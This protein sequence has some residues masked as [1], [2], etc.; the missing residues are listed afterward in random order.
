MNPFKPK[1]RSFNKHKVLI[2]WDK[3]ERNEP[4]VFSSEIEL[5]VDE[6]RPRGSNIEKVDFSS[7]EDFSDA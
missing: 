1:I 6:K 3:K 4:T 2:K 7:F 5:E